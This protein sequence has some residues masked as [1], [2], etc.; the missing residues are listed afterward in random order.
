V[1]TSH[2][3]PRPIAR[4][5]FLRRSATALIA[6]PL[7]C[8]V[9]IDAEE[10]AFAP[11][12]FISVQQGDLPI[13]LSAPHGGVLA[14]PGVPERVGEGLKKGAAGFFAARDVNTEELA[15]AIARAIETRLGRKPYFVIARFHRKYIDPNRPPEIAVEHPRAREVYDLYR[16]TLEKFC[17]DVQTRFSRGLLID[18]HGQGSAPDTVFRGTHD[19]ATDAMLVKLFGEKVHAGPQSLAG[20]LNA[21]GIRMKPS[22]TSAETSG[23][24]GGH[25]VQTYGKHEGFGAVQFEFGMDFRAKEAIPAAAEKVA[26]GVV[27][28]AKLYLLGKLEPKK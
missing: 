1:S 21:R 4:R 23:F 2:A 22:D 12:D 26:D 19:G 13:I 6:V 24:T 10:K 9:A 3:L 17:D 7:L 20:L 8:T 14:I 27:D 5:A 18:V 11:A 16:G 15:A 25:I 28:F